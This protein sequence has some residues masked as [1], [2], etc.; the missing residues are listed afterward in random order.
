MADITTMLDSSVREFE[1]YDNNAL[2]LFFNQVNSVIE[3]YFGDAIKR[4]RQLRN[5]IF[6]EPFLLSAIYS[7]VSARA[8][9]TYTLDGPPQSVKQTQELIRNFQY[10]DGWIK[11]V[12]LLTF[13]LLTQD[14]GAFAEIVRLKP[15]PGRKPHTGQIITVSHLD[16][17]RCIRTGDPLNPVIYVDEKGKQHEMA[18]YNV[19]TF[20]E[21]PHPS[22]TAKGRQI[23]FV[24]RVLKGAEVVDATSTYEYEQTTGRFAK[25]INLVGGVAQH[26]I[27]DIIMKGGID[28][29]NAGL[30]KFMPNLI[31]AALD[32]NAKV[33]TETI[34][35]ANLPEGY[36]KDDLMKWYIQLL[37]LGAGTDVQE[38]G[39]IPGEGLG[40][41]SQSS[42][43]AQK[44][45][46]KGI[47]L[48]I[49][50]LEEK[51][52]QA[53]VIPPNVA[54][55]FLQQDTAE[56]NEKAKAAKTRAET[57]KLQID[58]G[59][60]TPQIAANIAVDQGDLK[61]VFLVEMGRSDAT[62]NIEVTDT[63]RVS[64]Q[65]I[66]GDSETGEEVK[67]SVAW[68]TAELIRQRIEQSKVQN[69]IPIDEHK[70]TTFT[71]T[72]RNLVILNG[73]QKIWTDDNWQSGL[74]SQSARLSGIQPHELRQ[75]LPDN[76]VVTVSK[77][78]LYENGILVYETD[79]PKATSKCLVVNQ[80]KTVCS[81]CNQPHFTYNFV[82][83]YG[84]QSTCQDHQDRGLKG[85]PQLEQYSLSELIKTFKIQFQ[86]EDQREGL[87]S[88]SVVYAH[89]LGG[90]K[91]IN[92]QD[93][94][95]SLMLL[96]MSDNVDIFI[97]KIMQSYYKALSS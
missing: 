7:I 71:E 84:W 91:S 60:I 74:L 79:K 37:A 19:M 41:G 9:L 54:F 27:D 94:K 56:E 76:Y 87:V 22:Q 46:V 72:L 48:F 10:G 50:M 67:S 58:S 26:T 68:K 77:T 57:R 31:V 39:T 70:L 5:F 97:N 32:P 15:R 30:T 65:I 34:D 66:E 6:Q 89:L 25:R 64:E 85:K 80:P 24:S 55:K 33:T 4:D 40:T 73:Q 11:F 17:S 36:N 69:V 95:D 63:E 92:E 43:L 53:K 83:P 75:R 3:P 61:Q 42:T 90:S 28:A 62:V 44:S 16:A 47:L 29:D 93:I 51:F 23:S 35:F 96:K 1:R 52:N 12:S 18:W 82:F 21:F 59:E 13:D 20:E 78:K 86:N 14:N 88:A 81:V 49:K 8:A 38:F 2:T 45:K